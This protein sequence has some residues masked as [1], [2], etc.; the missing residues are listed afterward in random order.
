MNFSSPSDYR[1]LFDL[2]GRV[3]L[4]VGGGSGIGQAGAEALAAMGATVIVADVASA[5]AQSVAE[6]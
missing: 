3:A 1:A 4:V 5:S 2:N 6:H